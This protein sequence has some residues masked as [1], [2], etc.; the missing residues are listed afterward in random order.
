[1]TKNPIH[2]GDV[3][4]SGGLCIEKSASLTQALVQMKQNGVGWLAVLEGDRIVGSVSRN[5]IQHAL[6][7]GGVDPVFTDVG[8]IMRPMQDRCSTGQDVNVARQI[9]TERNLAYLP[10]VDDNGM[11]VGVLPRKATPAR[12]RLQPGS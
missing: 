12:K 8:E 5:D 2:V 10:V 1:M 4:V 6:D 3:M 9:M 11:L 7:V